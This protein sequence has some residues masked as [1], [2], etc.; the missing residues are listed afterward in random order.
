MDSVMLGN[1][2]GIPFVSQGRSTTSGMDC[3]GLVME[4][5]RHYGV[6]LPDFSVDAFAFDKINELTGTEIATRAWEEI[7]E[8]ETPSVVLMR[9]HPKYIT[10]AGVYI[11]GGKIIHTRKTVGAIITP[12]ST[13]RNQIVGYYRYAD[14][15]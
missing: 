15:N 12:T 10:H 1:L 11:G 5:Y 14:N 7:H 13:L 9:I 8:P 4:V 3:W 6:K 2:I